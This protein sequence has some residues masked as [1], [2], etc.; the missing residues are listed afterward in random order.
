MRSKLTK[1]AFS[2]TVSQSL[3][4]GGVV[5]SV[6][7][8][9]REG[10]LKRWEP[11]TVKISSKQLCRGMTKSQL[12]YMLKTRNLTQVDTS[13][14]IKIKVEDVE[15]SDIGRQV[16]RGGDPNLLSFTRNISTANHYGANRYWLPGDGAII[17]GCLPAVFTD[18]SEQ[19]IMCPQMCDKEQKKARERILQGGDY[20]REAPD[21]TQITAECDEVCAVV[22]KQKGVSFGGMYDVDRHIQKIL[23][24]IGT[25]RPRLGLVPVSSCLVETFVNPDYEERALSVKIVLTKD[26]EH[27]EILTD[28]M[29]NTG[30]LQRGQRVLTADDAALIMADSEL[31]L[32]FSATAGSSGTMVLESVPKKLHGHD[33]LEYLKST[34]WKELERNIVPED[35]GPT[36]I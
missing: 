5:G 18:I 33:M 20:Y 17:I 15:H 28:T 22:G 7:R 14:F 3:S 11:E 32:L 21:V 16:V 8:V 31:N 19:A 1:I 35:K 4:S 10:K 2:K 36:S 12:N 34:L 25:G 6:S 23:H 30:K 24:V 29:T 9:L 13:K 27:L 26:P